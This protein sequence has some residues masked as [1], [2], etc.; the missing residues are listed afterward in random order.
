MESFSKPFHL[1]LGR[2]TYDIFA[3]H[4]PRITTDP[5]APGYDDEGSAHRGGVDA[6]GRWGARAH[7]DLACGENSDWHVFPK[8]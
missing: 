8:R 2:N 1:L 4:W 3:A 7:E 5:G 6:A